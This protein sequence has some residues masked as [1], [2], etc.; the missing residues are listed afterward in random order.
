MPAAP[1]MAPGYTPT[2]GF[3]TYLH[4][5]YTNSV[6]RTLVPP[7]MMLQSALIAF[8]TESQEAM[9]AVDPMAMPR[10][11]ILD[12]HSVQTFQEFS[13]QMH[14]YQPA[15]RHEHSYTRMICDEVVRQSRRLKAM[16]GSISFVRA[17]F[18]LQHRM[19]LVY[20][21]VVVKQFSARFH[22]FVATIPTLSQYV[23]QRE[24]LNL[25]RDLDWVLKLHERRILANTDLNAAIAVDAVVGRNIREQIVEMF[26]PRYIAHM[27]DLAVKHTNWDRY[28]EVR[29]AL[30]RQQDSTHKNSH[31][32]G[33]QLQQQRDSPPMPSVCY[34]YKAAS[35]IYGTVDDLRQLESEVLSRANSAIP[36]L[37]ALFVD[38]LNSNS[39]CN[40]LRQQQFQKHLTN[41]N[42]CLRLATNQ[43]VAKV[44]REFAPL[45][46]L[47]SNIRLHQ[48]VTDSL[49]DLMNLC[50]LE[51]PDIRS[52]SLLNAG[53]IGSGTSSSLRTVHETAAHPWL[54]GLPPQNMMLQAVFQRRCWNL[55]ECSS[56]ENSIGSGTLFPSVVV[57]SAPMS[58]LR[59]P[60]VAATTDFS[61]MKLP[62]PPCA[63]RASSH[64]PPVAPTYAP[65][66]LA[67]EP[68]LDPSTVTALPHFD[69]KQQAAV[70]VEAPHPPMFT[71]V[72]DLERE[73]MHLGSIAGDD[74]DIADNHLTAP[75]EFCI[76]PPS[77]M[78]DL[79]FKAVV[80]NKRPQDESSS[81]LPIDSESSISLNSTTT[82]ARDPSSALLREEG[83]E[84]PAAILSPGR[85]PPFYFLS[86]ALASQA[87][88]F[89]R[90]LLP[91]APVVVGQHAVA[92]QQQQF[93]LRSIVSLRAAA[94]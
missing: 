52:A 3:L 85:I 53:V 89:A 73:V 47:L 15:N 75:T 41:S 56:L 36:E 20:N 42:L 12:L 8:V 29:S 28:C 68:R 76:A 2:D 9:C 6:P 79:Q 37:I 44:E 81:V 32:N 59:P 62:S 39:F 64:V 66:S 19:T 77:R 5:P 46:N 21:E 4:N 71:T 34:V 91:P 30:W 69:T 61:V 24:H 26:L 27:L 13:E 11:H 22:D 54:S 94:G 50:C 35:V 17:Q 23:V 93:A 48:C 18:L 31:N 74:G 38:M 92:I 60:P 33:H 63:S 65:Q 72:G 78:P 82:T 49:K 87:I 80:D 45:A 83:M 7:I 88:A 90:V 25:C 10:D 51:G 84:D 57:R 43:I 70:A 1:R 58:P 67:A 86:K 16:G 40:E 55:T 14:R